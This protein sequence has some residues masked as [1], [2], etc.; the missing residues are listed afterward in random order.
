MNRLPIR[1]RLTAAFALATVLVL[2][3]AGLFVYQRLGS[4]LDDAIDDRLRTSAHELAPAVDADRGRL[5]P[6][7][8]GPGDFED[9]FAQLLGADGALLDGAGGAIEPALGPTEAA[10]AENGAILLDRSV[11]GMDYETRVLARP[12]LASSS[13]PVLVVGNSLEDRDDALSNLATSFAIGAPVAV[14]IASLLGYGLATAGFAPIEAMR[15]RAGE[16]SPGQGQEL[17]P[18]PAARDEI[19]RLAQTLNEMLERLRG[20]F[21]RERSFVSDASHELRTPIAVIKTELEGALRSPD[22]G[23]EAR[24]S[25]VGAIEECDGLAALAEDLLVLTRAADGALPIQPEDLLAKEMLDRVRERFVSRAADRG[26]TIRVEVQNGIVV[27]A[28][29]LRMRQA[30]GNLIDNALRHGD[31][32]V[33][34]R[35]AATGSHVELSVSDSGPGFAPAL[36]DVAFERFTRGDEARRRGGTGLGLAIVRAI[37][38]AHDGSAEIVACDRAAVRIRLPSLRAG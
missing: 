27:A 25:V 7:A 17:L 6:G 38:E 24:A 11:A 29:P 34:L 32:D 10:R 14:L 35:A 19:R 5:A 13:G 4:D 8:S 15:R 33:V 36:V 26:R 23:P 9:S 37:A 31:G 20:A 21:E 18:L 22:L 1:L 2:A 3:G 16:I 28:D 30:L 12:V